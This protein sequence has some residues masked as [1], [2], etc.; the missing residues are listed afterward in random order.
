MPPIDIRQQVAAIA[1]QPEVAAPKEKKSPYTLEAKTRA[2]IASLGMAHWESKGDSQ[3]GMLADIMWPVI[4]LVRRQ[5]FGDPTTGE[6]Q[7]WALQPAKHGG[8]VQNRHYI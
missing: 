5:A 6:C 1:S 3:I 8:E 4:A 7:K 2:L